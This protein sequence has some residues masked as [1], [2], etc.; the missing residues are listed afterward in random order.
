MVTTAKSRASSR[1]GVSATGFETGECDVLALVS[2]RKSPFIP[3][4]LKKL[5]N[6]STKNETG[7]K[8]CKL[9]GQLNNFT[10]F[11]QIFVEGLMRE[12]VAILSLRSLV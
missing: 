8:M 5:W 10:Y 6:P 1:S 11:S 3:E 9:I 4:R 12:G 2:R 7:K